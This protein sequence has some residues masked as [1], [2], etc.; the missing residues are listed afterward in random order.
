MG[1][2]Y[3]VMPLGDSEDFIAEEYLSRTSSES[4][5]RIQSRLM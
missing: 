3:T 5:G 4:M 1:V 2:F